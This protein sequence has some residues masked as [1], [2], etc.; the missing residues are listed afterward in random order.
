MKDVSFAEILNE[1]YWE[2]EPSVLGESMVDSTTCAD[3]LSQQ[4][5]HHYGNSTARSETN[6]PFDRIENTADFL[7][8]QSTMGQSRVYRL[9]PS[10][11]ST[12][13]LKKVYFRV[14]KSPKNTPLQEEVK[15]E[16][17][18]WEE[19]EH[20]GIAEKTALDRLQ[21]T[22]ASHR[23]SLG[24]GANRWTE[25]DLK[26]LYRQLAKRTHP[27]HTEMPAT[28]FIQIQNDYKTLMDFF[29]KMT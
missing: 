6:A 13:L 7:Q 17:P 20:W 16:T 1:I 9:S 26:R 29:K 19:H 24:H 4:A 14:S 23:L 12:A 21:A 27:D 18:K 15:I 5:E 25:E 10:Q 2:T 3:S 11:D 8:L 22:A 28:V